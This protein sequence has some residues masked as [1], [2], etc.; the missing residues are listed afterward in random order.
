MIRI[1]DLNE[2]PIKDPNLLDQ[3]GN[4]DPEARVRLHLSFIAQ[5]NY[6]LSIRNITQI[7]RLEILKQKVWDELIAQLE[8]CFRSDKLTAEHRS[9]LRKVFEDDWSKIESIRKEYD[10]RKITRT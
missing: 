9:Y 1:Q 5:A 4:L 7:E 6:I 2:R 3:N 8:S 10:E